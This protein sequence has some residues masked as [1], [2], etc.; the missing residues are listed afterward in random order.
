MPKLDFL[1]KDDVYGYHRTVPYFTLEADSKKSVGKA[2]IDGNLIIQGDNL[3]ALKA[4]LP[5]YENKIKCIYI[6][7]P[8]N[9]G[10]DWQYND[11][12]S[13]PRLKEW[14]GKVV[15]GDDQARHDKWLCMMWP[16]LQLLWELLAEDGVIFISID[17]NEQHHLR[18]IMDEIFGEENFVANLVWRKKPGGGQDTKYFAREHE[19]IL[20][21][22]KSEAF[23]LNFRNKEIQESDFRKIKNGRKCN[24]IK[25]EK[26]GSNAYRTDRPT[27]FY[28]IKDPDGMD[29]YPQAPDGKEGNWRTKPTALDEQHIHW[30]K[31][32]AGRWTPYE[33]IY[34]DEVK[35][36]FKTIKER[37]IFYDLA[38]TA[39]ATNEQKYIFGD[40]V[41]DYSKPADLISR[42]VFLATDKDSI[43]LDSFA[44]SG[45]TAQAVLELNK[46]DG[47][48]RKFILVECEEEI[49]DKI[50]AERVKRVIK[51]V[52]Q[53]K[54]ETLKAGLGGN[55]T[56]CTL[57]QEINPEKILNG[58]S[59]PDYE[60]LAAHVFWLAT[61]QTLE[62]KATQ[63]KDWFIGETATQ[64]L[65]LIYQPDI[66]FLSSE[67]AALTFEKG[68]AIQKSLKPKQKAYVFAST[69]YVGHKDLRALG[70]VFCQLPWSL[71]ERL[72]ESS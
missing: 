4:L 49:A 34:F 8:Y 32:K 53:A 1:G 63:R 3:Y 38:T 10:N 51:G 12:V 43:I 15:D 44:G 26:W 52:P 2:D 7:P 72:A 67:E 58:E 40:K 18:A 71:Q 21:Y 64:H 14:L 13:S 66:D 5:R 23:E 29:F 50:T 56:Y 19:N 61:G 25:L 22:V 69:A 9:T 41:F 62:S 27:M 11:N 28:P 60:T 37:T 30:E 68:K 42:L 59:L 6:D 65:Y 24:F 31:L 48:D 16:R 46:E 55:F 47:G 35:D 33:V 36:N 70:L 54:S 39:E 45:T 20:S 17:D 57:G